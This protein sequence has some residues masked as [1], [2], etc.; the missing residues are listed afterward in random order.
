MRGCVRDRDTCGVSEIH[1][2]ILDM[3]FGPQVAALL[4]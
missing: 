3:V 4:H 2:I 1:Q